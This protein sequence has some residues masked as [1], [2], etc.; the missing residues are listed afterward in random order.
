MALYKR[1]DSPYWWFSYKVDG[2]RVFQSSDTTDKDLAE[3]IYHV[4]RAQLIEGKNFPIRTKMKLSLMIDSYLNDYSKSSKKSYVNDITISK[5]ILS[6]FKDCLLN[7]ITPHKI[8][9]YRGYRL[10][11]VS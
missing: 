6:Y 2:I 8:E 1:K 10:K 5:T 3:K 9:L 4:K 7:D 11:S